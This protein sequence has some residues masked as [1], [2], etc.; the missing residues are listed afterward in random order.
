IVEMD[1]KVSNI[2]LPDL[3]KAKYIFNTSGNY[4]FYLYEKNRQIAATQYINVA[5]PI[6]PIS[7]PTASPIVMSPTVTPTLTIAQ[8][9]TATPTSVSTPAPKSPGFEIILAGIGI[10]TALMLPRK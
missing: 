2:T 6:T 3:G 5:A 1:K 8:I 9:T 4:K 10:I 7:T